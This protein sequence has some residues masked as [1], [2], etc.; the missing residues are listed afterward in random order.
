MSE[1]C[2]EMV[3]LDLIETQWS[4]V[5]RA[6][7]DS[8]ASAGEARRVL[9][10]RYAAAI[11]RYVG[12]IVRDD[13]DADEIAQ[14][15]VV[16]LLRGDFAGA[17]PQRGRFRDLLRTA[18]RNMVRGHWD[19]ERRRSTVDYDVDLAAGGEAAGDEAAA[20]D[21][22]LSA[23][24]GNVLDLAWSALEHYERTHAGSVAHTVLKLRTVLPDAGS[25]ELAGRLSERIGR[26][27][28]EAAY[29][30]QLRRAR[31]RF[32]E[33]VVREVADALDSP[34]PARVADELV[35]L[36][37][38]ESVKEFLPPDWASQSA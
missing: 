11:R 1:L 27:V 33:F 10:T 7:A 12:A 25:A 24:R 21:P 4:M 36:G 14:D 6:H 3:R 32:A 20:D 13:A 22:W 8:L 9:V 19:K 17:D 15:A 31:V 5:R 16:R 28:G 2:G 37:L 35:V 29:R 30:Q 38:Y 34:D 18:V 26:P 23:W